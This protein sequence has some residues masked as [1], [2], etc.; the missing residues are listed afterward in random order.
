[1]II[2]EALQMDQIRYFL[3][4][5]QQEAVGAVR[6]VL[7]GAMGLVLVQQAALVVEVVFFLESQMVDQEHQVKDT[8]VEQTKDQTQTSMVAV[9]V[10]GQ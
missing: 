1:M 3:R 6:K 5:P 8:L 2:E 7:T 4:L 9:E 10:Q